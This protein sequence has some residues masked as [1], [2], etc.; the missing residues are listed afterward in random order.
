[1]PAPGTELGRIRITGASR[2]TSAGDLKPP[3]N[4]SGLA[5]AS[6]ERRRADSNRRIEVLQTSALPLGYG[7]ALL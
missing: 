2:Q 6:P 7:A 1:M 4:D 5:H 3:G